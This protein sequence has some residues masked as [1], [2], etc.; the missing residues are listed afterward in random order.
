VFAAS[1]RALRRAATIDE[2]GFLLDLPRSCRETAA[3]KTLATPSVPLVF[4]LQRQ[5]ERVASEGLPARWQ[6]HLA[7]RTATMAWARDMGF[8]PF[9]AD[10]EAR[11]PT[12]SCI[13]A[14]GGDVEQLTA[15]ARAAGFRIDQGYGDLRGKAFRIG[16]MGDH[17]PARLA[18][19]LAAMRPQ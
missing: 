5:L 2:R 7:M 1:D 4:A 13:D 18:A 8:A 19:L 12:V 17:S 3:G 6:R 9:V 10:A 11:S 15:R 14:R 16:H